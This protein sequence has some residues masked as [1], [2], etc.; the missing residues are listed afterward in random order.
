MCT[1]LFFDRYIQK[2]RVWLVILA[3]REKWEGRMGLTSRA[4]LSY[5]DDIGSR[6]WSLPCLLDLF[7][8]K[9]MGKVAVC[10]SRQKKLGATYSD[11]NDASNMILGSTNP[12]GW[13]LTRRIPPLSSIRLS[14]SPSLCLG[15]VIL[16]MQCSDAELH[17][18][19]ISTRSFFSV[20]CE[21]RALT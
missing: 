8:W 7:V 15:D 9:Q 16:W 21:E 17:H 19:H 11:T 12:W 10:T 3:V 2:Y 20:P 18:T 5:W 6:E 13:H 1:F 14:L 4:W